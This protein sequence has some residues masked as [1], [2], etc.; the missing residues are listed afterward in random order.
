MRHA[1]HPAATTLNRALLARCEGMV[2]HDATWEDHFQ[3]ALELHAGPNVR[4]FELART[5]LCFGERLRRHRR[6]KDA[7]Q[8][9][10]QAWET[11]AN[12]GAE[13]WARRTSQEIAAMGGTTPGPISH[14][15]DLL[16]PQEFQVAIAVA[17]G[18][19]NKEAANA[20]FLSQKTVEFHLSAIYR[21]WD[22]RS[23]QNWR[24]HWRSASR[25][26]GQIG[27]RRTR[28]Q[29]RRSGAVTLSPRADVWRC[30]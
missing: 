5:Q 30:F 7:R 9:L 26:D 20:L 29:P 21:R 24:M 1:A 13:A 27:E 23:A 11:F 19:T 6:R 15:V 16:T 4:P 18:A 22:L 28:G 12:L 2:A 14:A 8:Q 25:G 17:D 3:R 10:T